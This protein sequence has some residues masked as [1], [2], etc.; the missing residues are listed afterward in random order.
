[1]VNSSKPLFKD[2]TFFGGFS[3]RILLVIEISDNMCT[4]FM[5]KCPLKTDFGI[6][7]WQ[8]YF[9]Y[10]FAFEIQN[11]SSWKAFCG[12]D[13]LHII[14]QSNFFKIFI[15]HCNYLFFSQYWISW[16]RISIIKKY[17][18]SNLLI[19]MVNFIVLRG[20]NSFIFEMRI[21]SV[22]MF[23]KV[24]HFLIIVGWKQLLKFWGFVLCFLR[25]LLLSIFGVT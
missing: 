3:L 1:M 6:R 9:K 7:K 25:F 14:F 12:E 8:S 16:W 15:D 4:N 17:F 13:G 24:R 5:M 21:I 11:W 19:L 18:M 2:F 10:D 23:E 20:H 22:F